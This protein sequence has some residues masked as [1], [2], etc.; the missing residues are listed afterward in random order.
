M[1]L[2]D[3]YRFERL[4]S[5]AKS[6]MDCTFSTRSYPGFEERAITRALKAIERR[7][8]VEA[9]ALLFITTIYRHYLQGAHIEK[10]TKVYL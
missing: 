7:D 5:K 4:A 10:P 6:R 9:G 3:Y 8:A 1:I 2:T